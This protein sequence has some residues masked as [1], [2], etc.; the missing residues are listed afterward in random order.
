MEQL[1][2]TLKK[3]K[4]R[5][6]TTLLVFVAGI[7]F[8]SIGQNQKISSSKELTSEVKDML[9]H[10]EKQIY[11]TQNAGQ[12]PANV[13]F[14]AEFPLGKAVATK[15]GMLVGT[16]DQKAASQKFEQGI[17][18]EEAH[19]KHL[20]FNEPKVKVNGHGWLMKFLNS[21]PSMRVESRTK[22]K[23]VFNFFGLGAKD[24]SAVGNYQEIWYSNVYDG[25]DVR[26]YPSKEGTLEYDLICKPGFN[27][28]QIALK[29]EGIDQVKL[30]SNGSITL[31][32]S[33]GPMVLP[34]PIAYQKIN[35]KKVIVEAHYVVSNNNEISF[36]L[37]DYDKGQV[38]IIDPIALRWAT[39]V[40]T[41][42]TGENHGHGIWVDAATGYIY[43]VARVD[44]STN[45]ITG[46]FDNSA[47]GSI[48]LIVGK[49]QQPSALEGAGTRVWQTYIGGSG[50]DNPYALEQGPDGNLYMV[51]YTASTDYP[52]LGGTAFNG[53]GSSIDH[54]A[55]TTDNIF[56]TKISQD[57][58]SIKSAVVGGNGD[59]GAFDLR[60]TSSGD[61][62]VCGNTAS[63]NMA[64]LLPSTGA[65]NINNGGID[66]F[67]FK[68]NSALTTISW[69]KNFGGANTDQPTI[70]LNNS[71]NGDI[72][73]AGYTKSTNFPTLNPR[74]NARAGNR[75]G[76]LMK[77]S[78]NGT[79]K[80]S[81]YF[82]STSGKSSSILCMEFNTSKSRL[83]FGGITTGLPVSN[84]PASGGY[85]TSYLGGTNDFFIAS[86]DTNQT[87]V[88]GTYLG[89]SSDEINMMGLNVDLNN[90]VYIFGYS[91][92]TDMSTAFSGVNG[93]QTTNKGD[94]DKIF[95]KLSSGLNSLLYGTYYG[96]TLS[97]YDPVGERGIKFSDCRIYTIVT[98]KSNDVPLTFGALNT[99]RT[100]TTY[101][102]GLVVWAN[103]PDF[104]SNSI[105]GSQKICYA[106]IPTSLS[107]SVPSYSLP[108]IVR[109]GTS[110][111][112]TSVSTGI[113]YQWQSSTDS[114][115]WTN[116]V[117]GTTQNLAN[118]LIGSLTQT[119]YFRR[120]VNGDAC[121]I[122]N[123][124]DQVVVIKVYK[125]EGTVTNVTC[126]G[127]NNG[128]ISVVASEGTPPYTFLWNTGATTGTI[129]GL[130]PGTYTVRVTDA[131]GC[132]TDRTY[133][134]TQPNVLSAST[135]SNPATC[136][137]SNG[138]ATVTPSGGTS[139]YTYLWSNGQTTQTISSIPV[140]NYSVT[141]KDSKNCTVSTSVTVNQ[142]GLTASIGSQVNVLCK[143]AATGSV[144]I[145]ATGTSPYQ[146]KKDGG[147]YG[148]S[149]TFS[150]LS[151]GTYI[152]TVKDNAGCTVP[153]SVTIT[154]PSF[155][156]TASITNSTPL[157]F[158]AGGSVLLTAVG[159]PSGT[160]SYVWKKDGSVISGATSSTYSAT[161]SGSYTV[162]VT[163]SNNCSATSSPTVVTVNPNPT[164]S[165]SAGGPT[166]FCD[167]GNVVLTANPTPSGTYTYEWKNGS[168]VVG[169]NTSTYTA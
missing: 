86:M 131:Q 150:G 23:D 37:G 119:T 140:G 20:P 58:T 72:Y 167:G 146:Y 40:N 44:G 33:V 47:N 53:T 5:T 127:A 136:L 26:Y 143:G 36:S 77:L 15:E 89:G 106:S 108:R 110:S 69:F 13:L 129:S 90:D 113:A 41:N 101:E 14:K 49:Y 29:F 107:G 45:L 56:V 85:K 159:S 116:I 137:Q 87:F 52:L 98:S 61:I 105:T 155:D 74:Q 147:S 93:L 43:I 12:W 114:I 162:V 154:E 152:I 161:Q 104:Q 50:A 18:E 151:A 7:Q 126:N 63:T 145:T 42:S 149:N 66:G 68:I 142:T 124:E 73:V 81:S 11:F 16:Y 60:F 130:A 78:S 57:G 79:T 22:H 4:T 54:R 169:G 30:S 75:D 82:N 35:G 70:M 88:A 95:V 164:V 38:L 21:S 120:V 144:T 128:S 62:L 1:Y 96:G 165:I 34:A 122:P 148:S 67:V 46:P 109:N 133:T 27:N 121:I 84:V 168:S 65:S 132:F 59:D 135:S 118:S 3:A 31:N 111:A 10:Y 99:T 9:E 28:N 2:T 83:Y 103:P 134:V 156:V 117:G 51:G 8:S 160:Y 19:N 166:T 92:S 39:W 102:P 123:A 112:H 76:F 100:S 158:C 6:L 141:V 97:D 55:Q 71:A 64:T 153:V 163:S 139:P 48:D 115:N 138:S 25:V 125:V 24:V 80:W 94:Y 17:R 32:T 91:N 157:T